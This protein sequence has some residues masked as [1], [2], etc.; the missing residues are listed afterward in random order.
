MYAMSNTSVENRFD[1]DCLILRLK[2][3]QSKISVSPTRLIKLAPPRPV[4]PSTALSGPGIETMTYFTH[5]PQQSSHQ[6]QTL[7][8]FNELRKL[9]LCSPPLGAASHGWI[10]FQEIHVTMRCLTI[11]YITDYIVCPKLQQGA[12]FFAK[13]TIKVLQE[14]CKKKSTKTKNYGFPH[15]NYFLS[16]PHILKN[17]SFSLACRGARLQE[18]PPLHVAAVLCYSI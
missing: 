12:C 9:M 3:I 16:H 2:L 17:T 7:M 10:F 13:N 14:N 11:V 1:P 8:K 6:R 4:A 5:E 18:Y 15:Q